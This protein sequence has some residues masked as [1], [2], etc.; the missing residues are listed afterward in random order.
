MN[1]GNFNPYELKGREYWQVCY[2]GFNQCIGTIP[3]AFESVA[4]EIAKT[5]REQGYKGVRVE[6]HDKDLPF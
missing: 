4:E 2:I 1:K 3:V 6:Y 5:L